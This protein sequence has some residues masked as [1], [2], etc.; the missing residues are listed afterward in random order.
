MNKALN[1]YSGNIGN[2]LMITAV[3]HLA[4]GFFENWGAAKDIVRAG[5]I[6]TVNQTP[7][8][9]GFF[10]FEICGLFVLLVGALL[11]QYLNEYKTPIPRKY[12]YYLLIIAIVG[13]VLDPVSGFCI[14]ILISILIIIFGNKSFITGD[15][16]GRNELSK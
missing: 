14:F 4:I 10:W 2:F 3:L 16:I 5:I 11:Q 6:N 9:F 1:K 15:T 8:Q 13:C 7:E 12:G